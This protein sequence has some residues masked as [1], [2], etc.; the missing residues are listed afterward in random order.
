MNL[1]LYLLRVIKYL[2]RLTVLLSI[3]FILMI[4]TKSASV[5]ADELLNQL[6]MSDRGAMLIVALL[7]VSLS[8]PFFG[9]TRKLI[10]VDMPAHRE[11]IIDIMDRTGYALHNEVDGRMIFRV[12]SLF[13]RLTMLGDDSIVIESIDKSIQISGIRKDVVVAGYRLGAIVSE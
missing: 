12:T 10:N 1:G 9:Y 4:V 2:L 13:R 7:A 6:F 3:V 5:D 8:Y 11:K